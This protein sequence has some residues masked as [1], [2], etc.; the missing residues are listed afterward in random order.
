MLRGVIGLLFIGHGTG[1][2]FGWFGQRG[3][4]GTGAFFESVGYEPGKPLAV[5]AGLTETV[6]GLL[7]VLDLFTPLA[8]AAIIGDMLNA[9]TVKSAAGFWI[10]DNGF[11]YETV[12]IVAMLVLAIAS[13][14]RYSLDSGRPW[15]FP[16][17]VRL[18][19]A[20]VVGSGAGVVMVLMRG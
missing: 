15:S 4:S 5:L 1:K 14:G 2:L 8:A 10:A 19:V 17:G 9:A 16:L 3:L 13:P 20:V 12:L 11:E 18:A 6:G 7:L